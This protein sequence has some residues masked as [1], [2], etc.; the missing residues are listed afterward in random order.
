MAACKS[1]TPPVEE[2]LPTG[3]LTATVWAG[4]QAEPSAHDGGPVGD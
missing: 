3:E 1:A 2:D 4:V